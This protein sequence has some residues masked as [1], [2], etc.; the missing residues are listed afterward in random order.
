MNLFWF[1]RAF[2]KIDFQTQITILSVVVGNFLFR[3]KVCK[4]FVLFFT[5]RYRNSDEAVL[6]I[7][8]NR[9]GSQ[10]QETRFEGNSGPL[11]RGGRQEGAVR[12]VQ[13]EPLRQAVHLVLHR[14]VSSF[15][16]IGKSS[17]FH[18]I[19]RRTFH[20]PINH[21]ASHCAV[22]VNFAV[23]LRGREITFPIRG[24]KRHVSL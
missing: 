15:F 24:W 16:Q 20:G 11:L 5:F 1:S 4:M 23:V 2:L 17:G 9:R 21:N 12:A 8:S 3:Q 6:S 14:W 19:T 7:G 22:L 18:L 13:A 10:P